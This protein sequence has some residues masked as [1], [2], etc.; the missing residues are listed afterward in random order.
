MC[1]PSLACSGSAP[2]GRPSV[3]RRVDRCVGRPAPAR[4][5]DVGD[6]AVATA[7]QGAHDPLR[8]P[9]VAE[10]PADLLDPAGDSGLGDEAA[11]PDR[12]HQLFLGHDAVAV[13]D[14]VGQTS[15][16]W[17]SIGTR[18]PVT[19]QLEKRLV[20]LHAVAEGQ[21]HAAK[22]HRGRAPCATGERDGGRGVDPRALLAVP[23]PVTRASPCAG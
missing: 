8:L 14:Q 17:G 16:A 21:D 13:A 3:D 9:V 23:V 11:A 22:D 15:K 20:E 10:G 7:V 6:E 2:D 1:S 5:L 4:A 18:C 12:V 19:A